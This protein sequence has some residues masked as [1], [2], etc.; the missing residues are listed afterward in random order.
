M[1]SKDFRWL[2]EQSLGLSQRDKLFQTILSQGDQETLIWL[3]EQLLGLSQRDKLFQTILVKGDIKTLKWL[4]DQSLGLSQRNELISVI[5][6]SMKKDNQNKNLTSAQ[7]K[8]IKGFEDTEPK[9]DSGSKIII[10]LLAANPLDQTHLRLDEETRSIDQAIQS[11]NLR[12]RFK[13]EQQWAVKIGD[14][15]GIIMRFSPHIIHFCGHGSIDSK[16]IL[17]DDEGN[18][19]PVSKQALSGLFKILKDNIRCVVLNSC[20]S[21]DQAQVI[22]K[23][24]EC[25]IGM[26][27]AIGD[28]SAINFSKG[29]YRALSYGRN[30]EE[31]FELG[32][33]QI[34]LSSLEEKDTPK[35]ITLHKDSGEITFISTGPQLDHSL[36]NREKITE[37]F[38][39]SKIILRKS[40]GLLKGHLSY[41]NEKGDE[42]SAKGR[43]PGEIDNIIEHSSIISSIG[44]QSEKERIEPIIEDG[45][46][47]TKLTTTED[48]LKF[49]D[50]I[51]NWADKANSIQIDLS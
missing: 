29:F 8:N 14:L 23:H 50:E 32:R 46:K 36:S 49:S 21:E 27:N 25:V 30:L 48:F 44:N 47:Y 16:I 45:K 22:S 9:K 1:N 3:W 19:H 31:A 11:G 38:L 17:E 42:Y 7:S 40:S 41:L 6:K 10:L 35:L 51:R 37:M 2:W 4:S 15:Q 34:D 26:S 24:I 5:T 33:N 12:A 28:E 43:I 18:S 39:Q 13:I 20:Y